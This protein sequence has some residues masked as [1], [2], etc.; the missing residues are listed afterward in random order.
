MGSSSA[1]GIVA[2]DNNNDENKRRDGSATPTNESNNN[3]HNNSNSNNKIK[4][5]Q[6]KEKKRRRSSEKSASGRRRPEAE[7]DRERERERERD[8][9]RDREAIMS[10][11]HRRYYAGGGLGAYHPTSTGTST[12][13]SSAAAI[14]GRYQKSSTTANALDRLRTHLSPVGSYYKP[15]FG[16]LGSSRR[17]PE[18]VSKKPQRA[19]SMCGTN[20]KRYCTSRISY[21]YRS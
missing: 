18:D 3:N 16:G 4:A 1:S 2:E 6:T 9:E 11:R 13:S 14:M 17:A 21:R 8:R 12:G 7:R 19:H 5:N 15:L 10:D 20:G